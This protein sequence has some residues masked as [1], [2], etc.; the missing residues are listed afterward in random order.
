MN[1]VGVDLHQQVISICVVSEDRQ[2]VCRQPLACAWEGKI[3]EWFTQWAP[4][5]VVVEATPS[6]EWFPNRYNRYHAPLCG[7]AEDSAARRQASP[8]GPAKPAQ[9][10]RPTGP[11]A[12]PLPQDP[13]LGILGAGLLELEFRRSLRRI[14]RRHGYKREGDQ[15][16][17]TATQ[18]TRQNRPRVSGS[19]F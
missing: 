7:L 2:V 11:P 19:V 3:R 5:Q 12:E 4:F 9:R 16:W 8:P 18:K 6:Y 15:R 13:V 10:G 17:P 14:E 1:F